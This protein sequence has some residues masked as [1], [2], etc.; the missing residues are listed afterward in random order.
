[1]ANFAVRDGRSAEVLLGKICPSGKFFSAK[2]AALLGEVFF[3]SRG[4]IAHFKKISVD[5]SDNQPI[6]G[7]G[8]GLF[9]AGAAKRLSIF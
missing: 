3:Q 9:G 8:R 7:S 5:L 2:L 6:K 4:F 1:V